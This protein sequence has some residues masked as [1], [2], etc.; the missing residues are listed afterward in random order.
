MGRYTSKT[1]DGVN[2]LVLK[3]KCEDFDGSS[4]H[5]NISRRTTGTNIIQ[6]TA[7]DK[8]AEYEDAAEQGLLMELLCKVGDTV[9]ELCRCNDNVYRIFPMEVKQ[10]VPYGSVRWV[11][12]K[13]PTVWNV[14]ATSD[15]TDMYK[16]FYDFGISVFKTKEDAE[17]HLSVLN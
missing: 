11:K 4:E 17:K 10:V 9:W 16:S 1:Q 15:Y 6:G 3:N 14:Y 7:I 12:E 5:W 8:F 2:Q 13:D